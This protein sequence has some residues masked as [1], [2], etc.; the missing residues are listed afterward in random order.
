MYEIA[1]KTAKKMNCA[2]QQLLKSLFCFVNPDI[3]VNRL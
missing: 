3:Y 2:F 1:T